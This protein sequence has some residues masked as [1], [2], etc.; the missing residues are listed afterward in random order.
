MTVHVT[1]RPTFST[2]RPTVLFVSPV[3][4]STDFDI[5]PD[6]ERFVMV[7]DGQRGANSPQINVVLNWL[8]ELKQRVP[9]K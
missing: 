8:E 4:G 5:S 3:S 1:T 2:S 9:V 6:G 7:D